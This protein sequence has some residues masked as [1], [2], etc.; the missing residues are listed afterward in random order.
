MSSVI[1]QDGASIQ[2]DVL[3]KTQKPRHL[4]GFLKINEIESYPG[5]QVTA[6]MPIWFE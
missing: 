4:A 1:I 2:K 3:D 5:V 6:L